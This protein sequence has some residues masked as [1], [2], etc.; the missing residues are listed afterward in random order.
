MR[1]PGVPLVL[2]VS[3]VAARAMADSNPPGAPLAWFPVDQPWIVD[4]FFERLKPRALLLMETE[5]WPNILRECERRGVPAVVL[6]ARISD[7]H[8]S[9]YGGHAPFF[10]TVFARLTA[11]AAQHQTYA[12]RFAALGVSS[13]RITVTGNI[14]FDNLTTS[15]DAANREALRLE[16][17]LQERFP[18]I[19]FGSTRP[20]DES[21]AASCWKTWKHEFPEARLIVAP[22]HRERLRDALAAFEDPVQLRSRMASGERM[23]EQRVL[24]IDTLGELVDFYG[25]ATV[26]IIGGSFYPGVNGHN[27]LEPAA[28]GV[29]TVFGP[30]MSNFLDPAEALTAANAALQLEGPQHLESTV[31]SLL[32]NPERRA[33][34]ASA[35]RKTIAENTGALTRTLEV[36]DSIVLKSARPA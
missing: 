13:D 8:Y 17:G 22:R 7:K 21:L 25:L 33:A 31:T 18:V 4:R 12:E 28:L 29:P 24:F 19:V 27:P 32:R 30:Y 35:A 2:T 16:C 3:T 6:N 10:K 9:R 23:H 26:A 14:K 20:G 15:I 34:L 1:Y 5:I 36:V 11:V